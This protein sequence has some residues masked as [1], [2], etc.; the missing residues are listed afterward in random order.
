V[1]YPMVDLW[2]SQ[3]MFQEAT[4]FAEHEMCR[5]MPRNPV[6]AHAARKNCKS[7]LELIQDTQAQ[8][9]E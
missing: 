4:Q 1:A 5:K 9:T 7:V 8:A 2:L 3:K 6:L